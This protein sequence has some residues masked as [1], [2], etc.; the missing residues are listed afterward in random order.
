MHPRVETRQA[1]TKI[2]D[3]S[4]EKIALKSQVYV[5][6]LQLKE[7]IDT[8]KDTWT[9]AHIRVKES[10]D[11]TPSTTKEQCGNVKELTKQIN[12]KDVIDITQ[13]RHSAFID[14]DSNNEEVIKQV[15]PLRT[16]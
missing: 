13:N 6:E 15:N 16:N 2:K 14:E 8:N 12:P 5:N 1:S 11:T 3:A 10:D 9:I 7:E 4:K